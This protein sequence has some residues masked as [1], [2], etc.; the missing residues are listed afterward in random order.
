LFS[1]G[2][3]ETGK[4]TKDTCGKHDEFLLRITYRRKERKS[5]EATVKTTNWVPILELGAEG[6]SLTLLGT[7]SSKGLWQFRLNRN[8]VAIFDALSE[9]DRTE[10]A[11][12]DSEVV[13]S[14]SE[15]IELLNRYE[16]WHRL[17]PLIVH[18]DFEARIIFEVK[19]RGGD[20]AVSQWEER[21][22]R[23]NKHNF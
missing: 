8:E 9:E 16:V 2:T 22:S 14:W 23:Q 20:E 6:G 12:S 5:L 4:R 11:T 1:L 15:A 7:E 3:H 13:K 10:S 21:L 19:S 18:Q 17:F